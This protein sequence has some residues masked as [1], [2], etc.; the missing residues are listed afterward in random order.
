V[1]HTDVARQDQEI[2]ISQG[3][4][5]VRVKQGINIQT[6]SGRIFILKDFQSLGVVLDLPLGVEETTGIAV[7]D[8]HDDIW[9]KKN[10]LRGMSE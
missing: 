5:L 9:V 4:V 7:G 8:R 2:I 3:T 1:F 6:V 10:R